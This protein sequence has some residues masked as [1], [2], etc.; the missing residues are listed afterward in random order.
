[1]NRTDEIWDGDGEDAM[2]FNGQQVAVTCVK[3]RQVGERLPQ[4]CGPQQRFHDYD[5]VPD[6]AIRVRRFGRL[7][8]RPKGKPKD[9]RC[10]MSGEHFHLHCQHCQFKW[11]EPLAPTAPPS[12]GDPTSG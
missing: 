9:D 1:M 10:K 3:C 8:Y 12:V 11:T 6:P 5:A 7:F 4:Y 2:T